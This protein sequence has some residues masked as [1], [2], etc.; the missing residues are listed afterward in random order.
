MN[1]E[2]EKEVCAWLTIPSI[3][4]KEWDGNSSFKYGVAVINQKGNEK[5]QVQCSCFL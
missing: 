1:I 3:P 4:K 2:F 5:V